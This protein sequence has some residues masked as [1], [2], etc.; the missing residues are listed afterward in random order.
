MQNLKEKFMDKSKLNPNFQNLDVDYLYHLGLDSSMNLKGEFGDVKYVVLTRSFSNADFFANQFTS[1]YYGLKGVSINCK[2]IAKD[3]RYHIYKVGNTIII[4]HGVGFPSMLICLN[5]IVKLMWHAGVEDYKFI[6][7]SPGGGL[8]IPEN[9]VVVANHAI[10][11]QLKPEWSNIEFGEYYTYPTILDD[12]LSQDLI[13]ANPDASITQGKILASS[14]FYNGQA[15]INGALAVNY[16]KQQAHD[17]L[18]KAYAAGARGIDMESSCFAAFC[19]E[20]NIP[21]CIVL[22]AVS[23]R[24]KGNDNEPS[25]RVDNDKLSPVLIAAGQIIVNYILNNTKRD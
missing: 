19:S 1:A 20:M 25:L 11:Q 7:F 22:A 8:N 5:E 24:L 6:R 10:N 13:A 2:T 21:G 17:Y 15:R 12:K 23:D 16:T 3:E 14:S 18:A 4:S 9:S